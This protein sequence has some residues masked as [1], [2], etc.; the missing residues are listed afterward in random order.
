VL[1]V[2]LITVAVGLSL[3]TAC[4]IL[5]E[6]L[7][8]LDNVALP[9]AEKEKEKEPVAKPEKI[10]VIDSNVLYLML[11]G[12]TALQRQQYDVALE[13]YLEAARRTPDA[14]VAEKAAKIGLYLDNLPKTEKALSLWLSK[15]D[16]NINARQL[17]LSAA[18]GKKN[19]AALVKHLAAILKNNP[20]AFETTLL[21]IARVLKTEEDLTFVD[22]ALNV[23]AKQHPQQA[24]IFLTQ[25]ILAVR[26]NK[27]ELAKQ[28]V[29][30]AIVLQPTWEKALDF[31]AELFMYSGKVAFR[32]KQFAQ[33][34]DWFDKVKS[35]SLQFEASL[36]AVSV[37][38]AQEK[39]VEAEQRLTGLESKVQDP[40]QQAQVLVMQ[41]EL[42]NQQK[43]YRAAME[44]L[45]G[46]LE[47]TPD[48]R[49][50]LYTRALTAEKLEDMV[51]LEADLQ[52]VLQ[53]N[54]N[55]AAALN[56]LG[57]SLVNKTTRYAEAEKYLSQ[58]LK[59]QPEEAVIIDSYGWLEY[60][61][62]NLTSALKYLEAAFKKLP[63]NE[64]AAHLA[65]V[66]W[67]SGRKKDAQLLFDEMLKKTPTDEILLEFQQRVLQKEH[68]DE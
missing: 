22:S 26:Q 32:N 51:T 28:K 55:D 20:A 4:Q 13:A 8:A 15:D 61:K 14:R 10:T 52:K 2:K 63:E 50:L 38:F 66:L 1:F 21:D 31:E 3:I 67:V 62:G 56:A 53:Q 41:A 34:I 49:D 27:L 7:D 59:L 17:A 24:G 45:T 16:K 42:L 35:Q 39:F 25:S 68:K 60:K 23:L 58:A 11:I 30:Q 33:A 18:L 19:Q 48:Q 40:K 47:K 46:A 12:E 36:A 29:H 9:V 64:I 57:Y 65:E 5:P 43:E 6:K 44:L 37:L 54:P